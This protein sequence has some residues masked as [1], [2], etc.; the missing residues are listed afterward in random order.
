MKA[1]RNR[2]STKGEKKGA[3]QTPVLQFGSSQSRERKEEAFAYVR[4]IKQSLS[5]QTKLLI[6]H[7]LFN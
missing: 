1:S 3:E 6:K 2:F 4:V 5:V 7:A